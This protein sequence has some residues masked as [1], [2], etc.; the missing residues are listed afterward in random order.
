MY[1]NPR[2]YI[3]T[4]IYVSL[5]LSVNSLHVPQLLL[6]VFALLLYFV[7]LADPLWSAPDLRSRIR[8]FSLYFL[9][10]FDR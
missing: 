3:Y 1:A 8:S 10:L 6:R 9:G 7:I 2:G 5:Y 4:S